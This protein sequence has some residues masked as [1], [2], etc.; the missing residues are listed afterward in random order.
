MTKK[1]IQRKTRTREAQ[2]SSIFH[3]SLLSASLLGVNLL[4]FGPC[5]ILFAFFGP[6]GFP[7][8]L[9]LSLAIPHSLPA[10]PT[11]TPL[12]LS[13]TTSLTAVFPATN[14]SFYNLSK[15][16]YT[17]IPKILQIPAS[18]GSFGETRPATTPL[19]PSKMTW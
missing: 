12:N 5:C 9:Q 3:H 19:N 13:H 7:S 6:F 11:S 4:S 17:A 8:F 15:V 18:L 2:G 1:R 14:V 16:S 10:H